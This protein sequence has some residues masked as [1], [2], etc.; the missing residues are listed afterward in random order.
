MMRCSLMDTYV[1]E[2]GALDFGRSGG[3]S[4]AKQVCIYIYVCVCACVC[5]CVRVCV[6]VCEFEGVGLSPQF[7]SKDICV[8]L[9]LALPRC[10]AFTQHDT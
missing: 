10:F 1:D 6:G 8:F 7:R 2:G 5:V 4:L 9:T 3:M